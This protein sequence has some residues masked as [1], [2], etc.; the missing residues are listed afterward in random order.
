MAC[1][2]LIRS[3]SSTNFLKTEPLPRPGPSPFFPSHL[4][5]QN[6]NPT[7]ITSTDGTNRP[8]IGVI[9]VGKCAGESVLE[10]LRSCFP[11]EKLRIVEYHIF[12]ANR[13]LREAIPQTTNNENI[14]WIILTRDP[15]SRWISAFNWDYHTYHLNQYFYCSKK[16]SVQLAQHNNC[17][18]LLH[19][20]SDGQED[21][22]QFSQIH[23]L[24]YGHG[25]NL[26]TDLW[27][28]PCVLRCRRRRRS[29]KLPASLDLRGA[30]SRKSRARKPKVIRYT[31]RP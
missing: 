11:E 10:S 20:I 6:F 29:L 27:P 24:T 31:C 15:I 2:V 1:T 26:Q 30:S 3:E 23:H 19:G 7:K 18:Q 4:K 22:I 5:N 28:S 13:I 9:H 17:L 16:I 21:A 25:D 8:T 12:D 14:H